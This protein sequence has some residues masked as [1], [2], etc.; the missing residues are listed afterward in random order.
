MNSNDGSPLQHLHR[1]ALDQLVHEAKPLA[2]VR[3]RRPVPPPFVEPKAWQSLDD[4]AFSEAV[5]GPLI[6]Q[7][8]D[9]QLLTGA[10]PGPEPLYRAVAVFRRAQEHLARIYFDLEKFVNE[11]KDQG[12]DPVTGELWKLLQLAHPHFWKLCSNCRGLIE[13]CDLC[14]GAGF[15]VTRERPRRRRET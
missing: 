11:V 5:C 7:L 1:A 12:F 13:W 10:G 3:P 6:K 9:N 15:I 4:T 14:R 2:A 8:R